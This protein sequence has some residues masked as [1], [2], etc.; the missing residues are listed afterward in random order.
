[1]LSCTSFYI[2]TVFYIPSASLVPPLGSP[3]FYA[4][5]S[6]AVIGITATFIQKTARIFDG[7]RFRIPL[8]GI[9]VFRLLT[10]INDLP[11]HMYTHI[12]TSDKYT[13]LLCRLHY[14]FSKFF[15]FCHIDKKFHLY[16]VS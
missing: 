15:H 8:F 4:W 14:L 5:F 6:V 11:Y 3:V 13:V 16:Y 2:N 10:H 7:N 9:S 12:S 1:M